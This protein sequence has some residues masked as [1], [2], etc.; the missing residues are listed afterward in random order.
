MASFRPTLDPGTGVIHQPFDLEEAISLANL[1][2]DGT[3]LK[4]N[5]HFPT[6][7]ILLRDAVRTLMSRAQRDRPPTGC[8][9]GKR[10]AAKA[11][12]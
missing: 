2:F 9:Q 10:S 11:P 3:C 1:Y 5:I 6:D 8:P 7:W 12:S 4:T